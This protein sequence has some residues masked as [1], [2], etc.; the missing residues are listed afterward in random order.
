[1]RSHR[2]PKILLLRPSGSRCSNTSAYRT[3]AVGAVS[4]RI[5]A[6]QCGIEDARLN[7]PSGISVVVRQMGQR[8][9]WSRRV[10]IV[11]M[12]EL[13]SHDGS[14][15]ASPAVSAHRSKDHGS[16]RSGEHY[17]RL[18]ILSKRASASLIRQTD[19]SYV[20]VEEADTNNVGSTVRFNT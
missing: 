8:I 12:Q 14:A 1:M 5:L 4:I 18:L 20:L 6:Q 17:H 7:P 16:A 15:L 10:Q 19:R 3:R 13:L 11:E 2:M 9:F